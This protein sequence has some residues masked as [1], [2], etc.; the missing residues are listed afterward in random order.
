MRV[1]GRTASQLRPVQIITGYLKTA[2]GSALIRMGNTHVLC[3]ASIEQGVPPFL[4]NTGKGWVTAEYSMLPRATS[5]RS[6]RE[7]TKG[8]PS[9]RTHEIQRL[10]GRSLRSVMNFEALGERSIIVD[11]DVIQADGGTRVASITG[12]YVALALA[13]KQMLAYKMIKTSPLIGAVA[14]ISAGI[15][16]GEAL[17]DLCYE[18]DSRAEVDANIVM[19]DT[20]R[21]VEFQATA[22]Q[23]SFDDEQMDKMRAL[24]RL[25]NAE[26]ILLQRSVIESA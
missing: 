13:V 10:I 21:L 12:A 17:L 25:G 7:V 20:G 26:L 16:K 15:L 11:C 4:R 9:G 22:E 3:A 2:E 8:R 6:P 18:E 14:A 1:D 5:T 24:A 23:K 19:T